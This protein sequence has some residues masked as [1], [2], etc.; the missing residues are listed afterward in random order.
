[1]SAPLSG[2]Q[3]VSILSERSTLSN[4]SRS[5]NLSSST[6]L[7][8]SPNLSSPT[9][10]SSLSH[11]SGRSRWPGLPYVLPLA[12]ALLLAGCQS[13]PTL[14]PVALAI[15]T[16]FQE[17]ASALEAADGTRWKPAQP[18]EAQERGAW[19][20]AFGDAQLSSLIEQGNAASPTLAAAAARVNQAR[21]VAGI[22]QA[23]RLPQVGAALGAQRGRSS[24]AAA[25]RTDDARV[26]PAR[27]YQA[28]LSAS[29]EIDLFGSVS[30]RVAAAGADAEAAA[31]AYRSVQL[32]LQAD[33]AQT[34]FRLRALDAELAALTR[35]MGL[36]EQSLK[37]T[38]SRFDHGETG[39]FDLT[40]ARTDIATARAEVL[41]VQR[42][43]AQLDHALSL[44]LGRPPAPATPANPLSEHAALPRIPAGLPSAL[45]ERRPDI[46]AAQRAM[47]AANA[48]IGVARAAMFPSLSLDG[49]LGTEAASGA[50]LLHWSARSWVLGALLS[51]P[52]FDGGRIRAN[53]GRSEA[54]LEESVATY[55]QSVLAAFAEVEDNLAGL[56]I[57]AGQTEQIDA[58][59]LS[60]RRS[61]DLAEKLYR[62]GRS[63]YLE[64][65]DAQ[66][67]LAALERSAAQLRGNRALTT[68]AL[69]RS[70]GG[71]WAMQ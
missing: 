29:Y 42:E 43:R 63:S 16:A 32:S 58:A 57:L 18:A 1:M 14:A 34:Y 55:R 7:S 53:I 49:G 36:R 40:R 2:M 17:A 62:A 8:S 45:L 6:H 65:L 20:L 13:T 28:R 3:P 9:N 54:V 67:S 66:R 52:L 41:G 4:V 31:A 10:L 30:A 38:Q 22:I 68:V 61:V 51:T 39:E 25:G 15:P 60:A 70:L 48:R 11:A 21:A 47:V 27:L 46:A 24:A 35:S 19:W 59:V 12:A 44:L 64:L 23:E 5:T 56:R 71:S 69:I 37:V 50:N 33:V 26:A